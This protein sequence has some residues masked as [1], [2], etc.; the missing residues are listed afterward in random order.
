MIRPDLLLSTGRAHMKLI[1]LLLMTIFASGCFRQNEPARYL[2]TYYPQMPSEDRGTLEP[3]SGK[4]SIVKGGDPEQRGRELTENGFVCV[5]IS[6]F[7]W[8]DFPTDDEIE[9]AGNDA[10]ADIAAYTSRYSHTQS[11]VRGIPT[12]EMGQTITANTYGTV[13][14]YGGVPYSQST[15]ITTP[16]TWGVAYVSYE[17]RIYEHYISYWRRAKPRPLGCML[18]DTDDAFRRKIGRNAGVRVHATVKDGA[19]YKADIFAGD[20]IMSINGEEI[21]SRMGVTTL[22]IKNAGSRI[23][24]KILRDSTE[25]DKEVLLNPMPRVDN[26]DTSGDLVLAK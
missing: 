10:R 9:V 23:K 18:E 7:T 16:G 15:S 8:A 19:A 14:G 22:A 24:I 5:G 12:Y 26:F 20:V 21:S 3:W 25:M 13:G 17:A 2:K 4:V 1:V 11:G 6:S